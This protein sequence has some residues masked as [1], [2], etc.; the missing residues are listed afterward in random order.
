MTISFHGASK[1]ANDRCRCDVCRAGHRVRC[2]RRRA[3]RLE[4][5]VV[6]DDGR[7]VAT[8][9]VPHGSVATYKNWGC[10]C[11]PCT[12]VHS[13]DLARRRSARQAVAS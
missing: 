7:L 13:A 8:A 6:N 11:E 4:L 12:Q 2:E 5:R 9:D 1:Y 10:R 3:E